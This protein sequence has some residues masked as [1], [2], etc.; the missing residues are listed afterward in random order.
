M[1]KLQNIKIYLR[2]LGETVQHTGAS[3]IV[4]EK[5]D[6]NN[7]N[8]FADFEK[9]FGKFSVEVMFNHQIQKILYHK[10]IIVMLNVK[11]SLF[12]N[13]FMNQLTSSI[14]KY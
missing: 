9:I 8:A 5:S 11:L 12:N 1:E 3:L 10:K 4:F 14:T 2:V 13:D 6:T 7:Q